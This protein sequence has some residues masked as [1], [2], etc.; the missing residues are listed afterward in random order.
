[1]DGREAAQGRVP[2][3]LHGYLRL[4]R[5]PGALSAAADV[6]AGAAL[7][8]AGS[9]PALLPAA[10]G[11]VLLYA[12]GMALNDI[13]DAKKDRAL[14]PERPI[15]SGLVPLFNARVLAAALLALGAASAAG[16]GTIHLGVTGALVAAIALYD[17]PAG[18]SR[19]W[20]PPLMGACRGLNL[21]RGST[22][23]AAGLEAASLPGPV[24]YAVL[25][26]G[27]TLLST[28]EERPATKSV[29][30]ASGA[31]ILA[32]ALAPA[33]LALAAGPLHG[34]A[35]ALPGLALGVYILRPLGAGRPAGESVRRAVFSLPLVA[36]AYCA[37]GERYDL[38]GLCIGLFA[39]AALLRSRLAIRTS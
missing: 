12:G 22:L 36:A 35:L 21:L 31:L 18:E 14:H 39:A 2:R 34:A 8:G 10:A 37:A 28:A 13:L 25:V 20:G 19:L 5:L 17:S 33:W 16:G 26:A 29:L 3:R 7:A 9:S 38:A 4:V 24:L 27:V 11:S 1:M 15:P 23:G 32:G 30:A 6:A